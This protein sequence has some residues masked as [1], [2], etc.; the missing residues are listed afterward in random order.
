MG[1]WAKGRKGDSGSPIH[2]LTHSPTQY[3]SCLPGFLI[4]FPSVSSAFILCLLC[5][6][7]HYPLSL[8]TASAILV[9]P[10]LIFSIEV[11]YERRMFPSAPKPE[12]GMIATFGT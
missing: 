3:P 5:S 10:F 6:P 12:P 8:E 11:A 2:P 4:D 7:S 9:T 1:E